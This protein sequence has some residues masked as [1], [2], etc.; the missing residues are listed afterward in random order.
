MSFL[1][2][3]RRCNQCDDVHIELYDG[4]EVLG[5]VVVPIEHADNIA[6]DITRIAAEIRQ[7]LLVESKGH[8]VQ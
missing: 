7:D 8:T 6:T 4:D 2:L 5:S 1:L 3:V